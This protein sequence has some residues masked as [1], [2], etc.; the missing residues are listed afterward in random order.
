MW[1]IGLIFFWNRLWQA[2]CIHGPQRK[3]MVTKPLN[4]V[5]T[6]LKS[7][8]RLKLVDRLWKQKRSIAWHIPLS[9]LSIRPF[10]VPIQSQQTKWVHLNTVGEASCQRFGPPAR[11]ARD[12]P[13]SIS[14][15]AVIMISRRTKG[16]AERIRQK[17]PRTWGSGRR[18]T[19]SEKETGNDER[20]SCA[21]VGIEF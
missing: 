3:D 9:F 1:V 10:R 11:F 17:K 16:E 20:L 7:H 15:Q 19:L 21:S 4:V 8:W 18:R 5:D 12:S 2:I 13:L 6:L 14:A